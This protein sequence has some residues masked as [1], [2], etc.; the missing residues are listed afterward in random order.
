MLQRRALCVTKPLVKGCVLSR[1]MIY[2]LRPAPYGT[3]QPYEIEDII[4]KKLG[5]DL[6]EGESL[7]WSDV[8][9]D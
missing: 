3:L 4:G 6:A 5:R 8:I 9:D 7:K 2:A 1:D